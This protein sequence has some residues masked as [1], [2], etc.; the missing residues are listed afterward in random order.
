MILSLFQLTFCVHIVGITCISGSLIRWDKLRLSLCPP[1]SPSTISSACRQFIT[2]A[3]D[4]NREKS[5]PD[6]LDAAR[7]FFC[8]QYNAAGRHA[9]THICNLMHCLVPETPK[10]RFTHQPQ[11]E[12][13][14]C[15]QQMLLY[16]C[17]ASCLI[18]CDATQQHARTTGTHPRA[19]TIF[20]DYFAA[21]CWLFIV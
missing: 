2:D 3:S 12:W 8:S 13:V 15:N 1:F 14:L 11:R 17:V 5:C 6:C 19:L 21:W 10:L 4:S 9:R 18:E 16:H 7:L 20:V